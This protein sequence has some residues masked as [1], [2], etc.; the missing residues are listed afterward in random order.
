MHQ[1]EAVSATH[2]CA[3]TRALQ[4]DPSD[5]RYPIQPATAVL[6]VSCSQV[7]SESTIIAISQPGRGGQLSSTLQTAQQ[8]RQVLRTGTSLQGLYTAKAAVSAATFS[9]SATNNN[10]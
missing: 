8:E 10:P 5:M 2:I 9:F 3:M 7:H 6:R 4:V 1:V